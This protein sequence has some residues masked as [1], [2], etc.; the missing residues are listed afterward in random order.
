MLQL[1]SLRDVGKGPLGLGRLGR[2]A[3]ARNLFGGR[4]C[5]GW[6]WRQSGSGCR[7]RWRKPNFGVRQKALGLVAR[8]LGLFVQLFLEGNYRTALECFTVIEEA[9]V[10]MDYTDIEKLRKQMLGGLE[11]VSEKKKP[12]AMELVNLLET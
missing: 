8:E 4:C 7:C 9:V 6:R 5:G 1:E 10:D 12:L 2:I 11:K 3:R